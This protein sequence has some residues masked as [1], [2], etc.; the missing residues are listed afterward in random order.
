[1]NRCISDTHGE[2]FS[3]I[4]RNIYYKLGRLLF[5]VFSLDTFAQNYT[6]IIDAEAELSNE[7]AEY[8]STLHVVPS[9]YDH[10]PLLKVNPGGDTQTPGKRYAGLGSACF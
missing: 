8:H 9:I 1:M 7:Y 3:T 10:G 6:E 5:S 2:E 4:E